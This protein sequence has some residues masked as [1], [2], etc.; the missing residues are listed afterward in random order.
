MPKYNTRLPLY[1]DIS[2]CINGT[3]HAQVEVVGPDGEISL[4][5]RLVE[6]DISEVLGYEYISDC[7]CVCVCACT[8]CVCVCVC[9]CARARACVHVCVTCVGCAVH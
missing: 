6:V 4:D 3:G 7:V 1:A 5:S 8:G 2:V 9:V